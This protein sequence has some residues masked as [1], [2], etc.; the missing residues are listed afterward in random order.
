MGI[1]AWPVDA[2]QAS[3]LDCDRAATA[4]KSAVLA[5]P[6]RSQSFTRNTHVRERWTKAPSGSTNNQP[7]IARLTGG[8]TIKDSCPA[9]QRASDGEGEEFLRSMVSYMVL[10]SMVSY[11]V[12]IS[13]SPD[14]PARHGP[15]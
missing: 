9:A 1:R 15:V 13:C 12:Y 14:N 3:C 6:M 10:R 4:G 7:G 11:M 8:I 5:Y 2:S